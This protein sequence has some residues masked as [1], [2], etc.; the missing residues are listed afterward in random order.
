MIA[1]IDA[2][3]AWWPPTLRPVGARPQVIGVVDRPSGQ[4][5]QAVVEEPQGVE[6]G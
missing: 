3:D 2:H 1:V 5:A 6:I 4:P